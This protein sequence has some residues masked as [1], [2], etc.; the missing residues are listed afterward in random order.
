M[1]RVRG[2]AAKPS[3]LTVDMTHKLRYLG[4]ATLLFLRCVYTT[5]KPTGEN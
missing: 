4:G 5:E 2:E 3:T 1:L